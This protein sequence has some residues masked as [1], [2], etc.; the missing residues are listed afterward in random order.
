MR[1]SMHRGRVGATSLA[2]AVAVTAA[3]AV[4]AS[5]QSLGF[6]PV[7]DTTAKFYISGADAV[8]GDGTFFAGNSASRS[9][10]YQTLA[11]RWSTTGGP[12]LSLTPGNDWAMINDANL[13]GTLFVGEIGEK[14][15]VAGALAGLQNRR[16]VVFTVEA[17]G[18]VKQTA[19]PALGPTF[20]DTELYATSHTGAVIGG[21]LRNS[22]LFGST[23]AVWN[24]VAGGYAGPT[25]LPRLN[26]GTTKADGQVV[27]PEWGDRVSGISGSGAVAVGTSGGEAFRWTATGGMVALGYLPAGLYPGSLAGSYSEANAVSA[28]GSVTVGSSDLYDFAG[29]GT[30]ATEAVRWVTTGSVTTVQSLGR[31]TTL[32]EDIVDPNTGDLISLPTHSTV[33]T[34]VSADGNVI[35][36]NSRTTT[37]PIVETTVPFIWTPAGAMQDL[38]TVARA[39]GADPGA[40]Q[41]YRATGMSN[42]GRTITIAGNFPGGQ[43]TVGVLYI[44]GP[45]AVLTLPG[46]GTGGW[47]ADA[48]GTWAS[49][50]NWTLGTVPQAAGNTAVF[51]S[52]ITTGRTVSVSGATTTGNLRFDS[53]VTGTPRVLFGVT[54]TYQGSYTLAGPGTLTLSSGVA[55][56]RPTLDVARGNHFIN[57]AV[58][59]PGGLLARPAAG[60]SVRLGGELSGS[61]GVTVAGT[62]T[63]QLVLAGTSI[64]SGT[65]SVDSGI[66]RFA[67]RTALYNATPSNWTA[68]NL[69]VRSGAV[70][71]FNVGGA[72]EFTSS[73]LQ[74]ILALGTATGGFLGGSAVG[75]DTTSASFTYSP[76]INNPNGGANALGIYKLGA[77]TLTLSGASGFTGGVTVL[78]G[79]VSVGN[80][81]ALG[82]A[83]GTVNLQGGSLLLNNFNVAVG[84]LT[85]VS[86]STIRNSGTTPGTVTLTVNQSG[87]TTFA[88]TLTNS[89]TSGVNLALTKSGTGQLT[90]SGT[91]NY[92]G[93]T[94]VNAGTLLFARSSSLYNATPASW[95]ATNLIVNAGATAAFAAGGTGEFTASD[96]GTLLALGTSTGGFRSGSSAGISVGAGSVTYSTSIANPN[97]GANTL[98]LTKLGSG[99]LVLSGN[100][101]YTGPTVIDAGALT[102]ASRASL[103]N[104]STASW[105][106]ANL[107]VNANAAAAFRVGGA[108]EFG[109]ADVQ[110]LAA[111]QS[112]NGGFQPGSLIGL[113]T[114]SLGTGTF[115]YTGGLADAG[116]NRR[117]LLKAG[118][119]TLSLPTS[120]YTG[121]TRVV[122]GNLLSTAPLRTP[123]STLTVT[124]TTAAAVFTVPGSPTSSV[125]VGEFASI[126]LGTN[127]QNGVSRLRI[128]PVDRTIHRS[129]V[130][131]TSSINIGNNLSPAE[132]S[133][134]IDLGT[135][136]LILRGGGAAGLSQ[137]RG[138]ILNWYGNV[139]GDYGTTSGR[140]WY[141]A[142]SAGFS[143]NYIPGVFAGLGSTS[144]SITD[145]A[146]FATA[147]YT[148]LGALLNDSGSGFPRFTSFDGLSVST[149]DVLVKYTYIGDTNLDGVLDARDLNAVL[150]GWSNNL[151]VW[152]NGDTNY[153]DVVD[154]RDWQLFLLAYTHYQSA[155]VPLGDTGPAGSV[156]PEPSAACTA[157][158]CGF[159][160]GRRR[161]R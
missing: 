43:S 44:N 113:D 91:S 131:V 60:T 88:G 73:D 161:R 52:S 32:I 102:F 76:A 126:S 121:D 146:P 6:A 140:G 109:L 132:R 145:V 160:L 65:T 130:L 24:R 157:L 40:Y 125:V 17:G 149:A 86:G 80:A 37:A 35:V 138:L 103:Y 142:T 59:L 30:K 48:D 72:G 5:A 10:M 143:S 21:A 144:A 100:N 124:G 116:A 123:S 147:P 2:L 89:V 134:F 42:D 3:T 152:E 81:S 68:G 92:S 71:A 47:Y 96:L 33:A 7:F 22:Q 95:T 114:T 104:A 55:G 108:G 14:R 12:T 49:T 1:C 98:G 85:G 38:M 87:R 117:G 28:N 155:G 34:A 11:V 84:D 69:V 129:Q 115:T 150:N 158:L 70:A 136:D 101:S 66:L 119:G 154:A 31:L 18:V 105:T 29:S 153:D 151:R 15:Y 61:G 13:D 54:T 107:R 51:G 64:Y 122:A 75:F 139:I 94:T 128:T 45:S 74:T 97:A 120:T 56:V 93:P 111:L 26:Q 25:V 57:T 23:P 58:T 156:V 63:G 39:L 78:A 19:V 67:S 46:A 141:G 127:G 83:S 112:V 99:T 159:I 20:D 62:G 135:S 41:F 53:P 106:A 36:G 9:P 16:S 82:S 8:S 110:S 79:S 133:G 118:T 4:E 50:G 77:N 137:V 90:L 27:T 148:T